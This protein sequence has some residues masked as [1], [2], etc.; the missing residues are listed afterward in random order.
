MKTI[1]A[2]LC[3]VHL[4]EKTVGRLFDLNGKAYSTI[5]LPYKDNKPNISCIKDGIYPF[6]KEHSPH[7]NKERIELKLVEGRSEIQIHSATKTEHV[8][9]CIGIGSPANEIAFFDAMPDRGWI[10]VSTIIL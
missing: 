7:A 8:K 9:G 6:V 4:P 2:V 10:Q 5:E 1:D 3:R